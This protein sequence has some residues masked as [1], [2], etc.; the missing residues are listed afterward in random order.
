MNEQSKSLIRI[1]VIFCLTVI[2]TTALAFTM[3]GL[4]ILPLALA[5]K[6]GL[7]WLLLIP[8]CYSASF[9]VFLAIRKINKGF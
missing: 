2:A 1:M 5:M 8:P 6:H 4:T 7:I 9:L 3:V